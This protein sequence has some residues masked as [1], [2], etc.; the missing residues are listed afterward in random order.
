MQTLADALAA[1]PRPKGDCITPLAG[2]AL[3]DLPEAPTTTN[4]LKLPE[5]VEH[6][7]RLTG[8]AGWLCGAYRFDGYLA[9]LAVAQQVSN[10]LTQR[11]WD[12]VLRWCHYLVDTRDVCLYFHPLDPHTPFAAGADSS[13][14][15]GPVPGSS[16]GGF[17]IGFPG[18]GAFQFQCF[19][20]GK[21]ADSSAGAE[22]IVA[23]HCVKAIVAARMLAEELGLK[24]LEPTPLAMDA[25]AVIDGA[26]MERVS[27]ASRWLAA[28]QAILREM[29]A[30]HL[31]RLVKVDTEAH[32]ADISTKPLT[33]PV[34]FSMLRAGLLDIPEF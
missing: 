21:L 3:R 6:A 20:P 22:A 34:R 28:R 32:T 29:I 25:S 13:C 24:Q 16:Y 12:A 23:C 31:T 4:P 14:L 2:A 30:A 8:I 15:N 11:V 9:F 33:D 1:F 17:C 7:Q 19:V 10:N 26:K 27:R 5:Y 18:S